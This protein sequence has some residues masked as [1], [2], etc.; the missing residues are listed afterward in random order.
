MLGPMTRTSAGALALAAA[1][2]LSPGVAAAAGAGSCDNAA[3]GMCV[4][5]TGAKWTA[6]S[7]RRICTGQ[8][9]VYLEGTCPAK[10][11]VG[12]CSL[13]SKGKGSESVNH[14]Y[15]GFPGYGQKPR[16]GPAVAAAEQCT[17][18]KGQWTSN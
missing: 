4:E 3:S 2:L 8:R 9:L 16:Q 17:R 6:P 15:G 11:R 1:F 18:L 12:R 7:M 14:Y 10:G 5:Y 13:A